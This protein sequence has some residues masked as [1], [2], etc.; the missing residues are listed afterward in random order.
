MSGDLLK[1]LETVTARLEAYAAALPAGGGKAGGARGESKGLALDMHNLW[2]KSCLC[3]LHAA[4]TGDGVYSAGVSA[5]DSYYSGTV[6]PFIDVCRKVKET[7]H[8]VRV[9]N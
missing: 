7:S 2:G 6:Q 8:I 3:R 9:E 1:R 5:Y 4:C